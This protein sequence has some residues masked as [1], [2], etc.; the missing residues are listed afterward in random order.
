MRGTAVFDVHTVPPSLSTF[1]IAT[2]TDGTPTFA[3]REFEVD[4][5]TPGA[6]ALTVCFRTEQ[7]SCDGRLRVPKLWPK[8]V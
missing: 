8:L 4:G 7:Y 6:T 5:R 2:V 3:M 1:F